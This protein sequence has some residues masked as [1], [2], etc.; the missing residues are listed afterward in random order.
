MD[1]LADARI[2]VG[3]D[4]DSVVETGCPRCRVAALDFERQQLKATAQ[5]VLLNVLTLRGTIR[6]GTVLYGSK[7]PWTG[8]ASTGFLQWDDGVV[9]L[10]EV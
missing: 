7:C 8:F 3:I 1:T 10:G 5:T 4:A 2:A 6:R 9:A